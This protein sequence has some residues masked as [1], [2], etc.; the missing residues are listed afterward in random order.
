MPYRIDI[1]GAAD[2]ALALL[3]DLGAL[4]ID[5]V[6]GGVAAIL[7]DHVAPGHIPSSLGRSIHVTPARGRDDGS[8]WIVNPR[9]VRIGA[10]EIRPADGLARANTL[11][12]LDGAAFGTGLHPTTALCLEAL[13]HEV[14]ASSPARVLDVGTGSGI[15][16]LAALSV[17]VPHVTA[18]DSDADAVR[19][20]AH[21]AQLNGL[22]SRI[23]LVQCRP[24]ALG[25]GWPLVLAN[26]LAAPLIAM[27]SPL[28]QHVAR[29]GRLILSGIQQSLARD[30][31]HAYR[32]VGMRHVSTQTRD[33]WTALTLAAVR[34]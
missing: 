24:G 23:H 22:R 5:T 15:L 21:N 14:S 18:I 26:I 25:G 13:Q 34:S 3:V 1:R 4:D 16:A 32:R 6:P 29:G 8:V 17:G 30:V 9:P 10:L 33:G 11:R 28:S 7:P 19:V 31:E 12:M 2:D 27:A 20:A